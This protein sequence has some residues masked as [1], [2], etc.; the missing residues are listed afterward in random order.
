MLLELRQFLLIF[1]P[2]CLF[3]K[4]REQCIVKKLIIVK[5]IPWQKESIFKA[6]E[7]E[8][9]RQLLDCSR[10]GNHNTTLWLVRH[11]AEPLF[12]SG[13]SGGEGQIIVF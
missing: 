10:H 4:W 3:C 8:M 2:K 12:E 6:A 1:F 7:D 13:G 11:M 9:S 5:S